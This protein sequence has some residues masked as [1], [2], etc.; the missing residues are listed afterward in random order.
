MTVR[1]PI[2]IIAEAG[3]N[4]NGSLAAA[5]ELVKVAADCG[6]DYV[7]FQTFSAIDVVTQYADLAEYQKAGASNKTQYEMLSGLELKQEWHYVLMEVAKTEGIKFL[8]TSFDLDSA[9]FVE[10]LGLGIFKIPSG[11]IINL[12]YLRFIGNLNRQILLS[13]G[14]ST[15]GEIEAALNVLEKA[16]TAREK[17]TLLHCVTEY[18]APIEEANLAVIP[19]LKTSFGVDVGYSDHTLGTVAPIAAAALG[20]SVIE[21]HFTLDRNAEGP[22]HRASLE[23]YELVAM[24][25]GIRQV[26][27]SLGSGFKV[28]SPSEIKNREIARRSIVARTEIK[29]GEIFSEKNLTTKRPGN[30]ISPMRIDDLIGRDAPR[31]FGIDELIEI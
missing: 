6:A 23:P 13:T 19:T 5:Q 3:V 24:V 17:I 21:K 1:K 12:P 31:N 26:E 8:T 30:G 20:A 25:K 22:D 27:Q 18:P 2:V 9:Q 10:S 11:E 29:K 15:L 28:P 4:H 16:G 7:K 14:M